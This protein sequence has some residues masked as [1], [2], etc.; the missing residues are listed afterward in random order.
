MWYYDTEFEWLNVQ[1]SHFCLTLR[2]IQ[3]QAKGAKKVSHTALAAICVS[4][5]HLIAQKSL[6]PAQ[7]NYL[8]S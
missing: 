7:K 3:L 6:Q 2:I 5:R 8:M 1:H 4:C